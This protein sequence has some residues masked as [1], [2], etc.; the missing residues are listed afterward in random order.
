VT[1][2]TAR[3]L[4]RTIESAVS[5]QPFVR[6]VRVR[7]A[8]ARGGP[9]GRGRLAYR[10][11]TAEM[12]HATVTLENDEHRVVARLAYEPT[13]RYPLMRVVSAGPRG[14]RR[15]RARAVR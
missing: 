1:R 6:E 10:Y 14:A 11:L 3:G 12:V 2:A 9:T 8:P 7:I 13:L 4:A 15:S 5:L